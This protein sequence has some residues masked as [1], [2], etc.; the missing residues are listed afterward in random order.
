MVPAEFPEAK[1]NPITL[2]FADRELERDY[3]L[4]HA[5]TARRQLQRF[6]V[7]VCVLSVVLSELIRFRLSQAQAAGLEPMFDVGRASLW[8][9]SAAIVL[10]AAL[11]GAT[12]FKRLVAHLQWITIVCYGGLLLLD[13]TYTVRL[14]LAYTLTWALVNLVII[15]TALQLRF[16]AASAMGIGF[17]LVHLCTIM[18]VHS[19]WK[20]GMDI[21]LQFVINATIMVGFNLMLMFVAHQRSLNSRMAFARAR[22]IAAHSHELSR[23][24]EDIKRAEAQLIESEKQASVGRLIAG[25]LHEVNNPIGA[26]NSATQTLSRAWEKLAHTRP[27]EPTLSAGRKLL[28]VQ[29]DS[30]RRLATLVDEL[31]Q[32]V[33][34]DQQERRTFDIRM[35]LQTAAALIRPMLPEDVEFSVEAP[36]H[37]IQVECFPQRL[38]QTFLNLLQNAAHSFDDDGK[39]KRIECRLSEEAGRAVVEVTDTGRGIDEN[40]QK[41]IFDLGF[42]HRGKRVKMHLGLP[43]SRR[44]IDEIGGELTLHSQ[45]GGGTSVCIRL[46]ISAP[47]FET[48][49]SVAE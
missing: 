48:L 24:L 21:Q 14:P 23:A 40:S 5:Q 2:C 42:S 12:F 49:S 9:V 41:Q 27:A 33:S 29:A 6:V 47:P 4:H 26:L 46:P 34:L 8:T 44:T 32:F 22:L 31:R 15:Y 17:T 28:A 38:N 36:D 45:L 43:M 7:F 11:L 3:R 18:G 19:P 35:G 25:I 1:L 13:Q 37:P 30:G 39:P 20:S 16:F 10:T